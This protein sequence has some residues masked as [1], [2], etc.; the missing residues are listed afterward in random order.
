MI[1]KIKKLKQII[2]Q[3]QTGKDDADIKALTQEVKELKLLIVNMLLE[4]NLQ[5]LKQ[6][7]KSEGQ[8]APAEKP[9]SLSESEINRLKDITDFKQSENQLYLL[10][11]TPNIGEQLKD[12]KYR[13]QK[14]DWYAKFE[15]SVNQKSGGNPVISCWIPVSSAESAENL[16][17]EDEFL[18]DRQQ[19]PVRISVKPGDYEVYGEFAGQ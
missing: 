6:Y 9:S 12:G 17:T 8:S 14:S 2:R 3:A 18:E 16:K 5:E 11:H 4:Q 1:E 15:D 19:D 10:L 7:T 13:S